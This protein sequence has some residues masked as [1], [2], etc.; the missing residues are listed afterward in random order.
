MVVGKSGIDSNLCS[1]DVYVGKTGNGVE[2]CDVVFL[3]VT[4]VSLSCLMITS[5]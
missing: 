3:V 4:A 2:I 1:D 5:E